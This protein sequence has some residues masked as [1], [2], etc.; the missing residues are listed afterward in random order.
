MDVDAILTVQ[1][2]IRK[3]LAYPCVAVVYSG[4]GTVK[5]H[6][7]YRDI[8]LDKRRSRQFRNVGGRIKQAYR[9][10]AR[11]GMEYTVCMYG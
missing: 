5:I 8:E 3:I 1:R 7:A 4:H 10:R 2:S 6:V 11:D 9:D